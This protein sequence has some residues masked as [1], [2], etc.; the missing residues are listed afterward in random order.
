MAVNMAA[1]YGLQA[2]VTN[3]GSVA[4]IAVPAPMVVIYI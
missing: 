2:G 1:R 4:T 3:A